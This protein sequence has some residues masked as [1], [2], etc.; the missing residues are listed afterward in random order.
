[1]Q[2]LGFHKA[3]LVVEKNSKTAEHVGD[4]GPIGSHDLF[5]NGDHMFV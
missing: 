2:R 3:L 4:I 5:P 1:M